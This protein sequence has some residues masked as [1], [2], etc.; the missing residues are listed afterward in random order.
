MANYIVRNL[1]GGEI[2]LS[3]VGLTIPPAGGSP[4]GER[5]L[6]DRSG[7]NIARSVDLVTQINAGNI[8]LLDNDGTTALSTADS[9][10]AL[11]QKFNTRMLLDDVSDVSASS[12]SSG[13]VLQ[14]SAGSWTNATA[15]T[16]TFGTE[17]NQASS[18]GESS[19]SST[20][21]QSKVNIKI[22]SGLPNGTYRIGWYCEPFTQDKDV[23]CEVQIER[24]DSTIL[25]SMVTSEQNDQP[26]RDSFS[27]FRYE[28]VNTGGITID[29]NWRR[30]PIKDGTA[31]I[32][33]ARIEI[34]RVS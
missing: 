15:P 19:T 32:R 29:I 14:F 22:S 7:H 11:N 30:T 12:P 23:G 5:D 25:S 4:P 9:L 24:D 21:F 1:T 18:E 2:V 8:A 6:L 20:T 17:F 27:G 16:G 34:W 13:E 3:D 26:T 31:Y 10:A 28:T 33:R